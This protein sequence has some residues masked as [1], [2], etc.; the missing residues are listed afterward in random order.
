[1]YCIALHGQIQNEKYTSY[2]SNLETPG[3]PN[4]FV[5]SYH[6]KNKWY[7][8]WEKS[9]SNGAPILHYEINMRDTMTN[10]SF[11]YNT[12]FTYFHHIN[13]PP[14]ILNALYEVKVRAVNVIGYGLY[15]EPLYRKFPKYEAIGKIFA[16]LLR[17]N[18]IVV[19]NRVSEKGLMV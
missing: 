9:N 14:F 6:Y 11:V 12:T 18:N 16:T 7:L 19:E 15:T 10:Q 13:E 3:I 2:I 17:I 4:A 1:M 8:N 5:V